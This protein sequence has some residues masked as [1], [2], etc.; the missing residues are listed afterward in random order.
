[1]SDMGRSM[2]GR[3]AWG[4]LAPGQRGIAVVE[5]ALILPLL[6]LLLL[7]CIDIS[8]AL[9]DKSLITNASR[10]GA[11]AGIVSR[12]PKL[13][14]AEIEQVVW[15]YTQG[16]LMQWGT[17]AQKPTV[18][19][20]RANWLGDQQSLRV[21]VSF[22]F[23]GLGMGQLFSVLGQPWVLTASSVMLQE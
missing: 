18:Q 11:R 3:L 6:L 17:N 13:S 1:M 23:Q 5:F 16:S 2:R 19:I 12:H 7:G 15:S 21:T 10:E 4:G 14:D 9:L 8:L 20:A 22:T